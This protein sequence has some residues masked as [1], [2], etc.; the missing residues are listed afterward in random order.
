MEDLDGWCSLFFS[1]GLVLPPGDT[2]R[3]VLMISLLTPSCE[4]ETWTP[5]RT[6]GIKRNFLVPS[7]DSLNKVLPQMLTP[8]LI[9]PLLH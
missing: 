8:N 1:V 5:S 2:A 6:L 9:G 3:L 7:G 4:E